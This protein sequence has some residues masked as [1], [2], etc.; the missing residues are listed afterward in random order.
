MYSGSSQ[1]I[2]CTPSP[3]YSLSLIISADLL[4]VLQQT[5]S[6]LHTEWKTSVIH[7]RHNI[8]HFGV[9]WPQQEHNAF[10][11]HYHQKGTGI[12]S[13]SRH[14]TSKTRQYFSNWGKIQCQRINRKPWS[15]ASNLMQG[16]NPMNCYTKHELAVC[17][18]LLP[19]TFREKLHQNTKKRWKDDNQ[20]AIMFQAL[21]G[22]NYS[23]NSSHS[24]RDNL[25]KKRPK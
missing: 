25:R 5:V 24:L 4:G 15:N 22:N 20:H 11:F 10:A 18:L 14:W 2:K 9:D 17:C 3:D 23:H 19:H 8:S 12:W 6:E 13:Y 21:K 1:D 7:R 16:Y